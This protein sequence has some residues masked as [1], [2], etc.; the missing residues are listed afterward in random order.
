[1]FSNKR[2]PIV[3]QWLLGHHLSRGHQERQG[4]SC[5]WEFLGK[6]TSLSDSQ[7]P[8]LW[9]CSGTLPHKHWNQKQDADTIPIFWGNTVFFKELSSTGEKKAEAESK[10]K[11]KNEISF[12]LSFSPLANSS[13]IQYKPRLTQTNNFKTWLTNVGR[14]SSSPITVEIQIEIPM[15]NHFKLTITLDSLNNIQQRIRVPRKRF[16]RRRLTAL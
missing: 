10:L 12:V 8:F 6:L 11:C 7:F 3:W 14:C 2:T 5:G 9:N 1:M 13:L 15:R 16:F 4:G